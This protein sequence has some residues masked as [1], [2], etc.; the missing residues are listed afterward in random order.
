M[1]DV[2]S[3]QTGLEHRAE[4]D[5]LSF[6]AGISGSLVGKGGKNLHSQSTKGGGEGEGQ[7]SADGERD[8][9]GWLAGNS[10]RMEAS[11][12]VRKNGGVVGEEEEERREDKE[13]RR[14]WVEEVAAGLKT[15]E[16]LRAKTV[17]LTSAL[18]I[19]TF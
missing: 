4:N 8:G 18:A 13:E 9:E 6:F 7:R 12:V 19:R 5:L 10:D 11:G 1:S 16:Y 14:E 3:D 15:R 17:W 2:H